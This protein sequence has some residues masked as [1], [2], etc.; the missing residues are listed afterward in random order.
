MSNYKPKLLKFADYNDPVLH[1]KTEPVKFPLSEE[2][3]N[4]IADMIYSIQP[5]QLKRANA[6]WEVPAGMAANQWGIAK[7][8]FLFCPYGNTSTLKVIINPSYE[9][10]PTL[11]IIA[12]PE[13]CEWEG[14]FSVPL[15]TGNIKRSHKIKIK[16]Q[17]QT[18]KVIEDVMSG[19][20]ARVWQHET[21]H[22]NGHLYDDPRTGKCIEKKTFNNLREVDEFY[23]DLRNKRKK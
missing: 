9:H 5:E 19:Y 21:D 18:G 8:I 13:S 1:Q 7:S 3:K 11:A 4:I 15:A 2:D 20:N 14:C 17:D 6:A 23:E 22:L 10:M 16:Y 12:A